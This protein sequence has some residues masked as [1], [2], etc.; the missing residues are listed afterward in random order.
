MLYKFLFI[1]KVLMISDNCIRI[2]IMSPV[3]ITTKCPPLI[4]L[5]KCFE[6][7]LKTIQSTPDRLQADHSLCCLSAVA[8]LV[9]TNK[10]WHH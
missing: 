9:L 7:F 5:I 1:S 4:A 10:K 6:G 2:A 3:N 8:K